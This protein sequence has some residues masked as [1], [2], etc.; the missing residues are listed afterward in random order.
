M[1]ENKI[2]GF[3][4]VELLIAIFILTMGILGILAIFP[5]ASKVEK[6]NRML[7]IAIQLGQEKMEETLSQY[8]SEISVGAVVEGYGTIT[9]FPFHKRLIRIGY[10]DPLNYA[11]TDTDLGI[12]KIEMT[13][14]WRSSLGASEKN[15]NI[16]SITSKR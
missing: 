8:Y 7:T 4:L 2:T 11:T 6:D 13:I 9:S 15:I 14:S 10:Y 12:K 5:M 1:K 16:A 3:T